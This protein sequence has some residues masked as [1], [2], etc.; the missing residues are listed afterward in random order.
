MNNKIIL[1]LIGCACIGSSA[2]AQHGFRTLDAPYV[3]HKKDSVKHIYS[4]ARV[5]LLVVKINPVHPVVGEVR[6]EVEKPVW[7]MLSLEA[8]GGYIYFIYGYDETGDYTDG[9][10]IPGSYGYSIL[11]DV[12]FYFSKYRNY[13]GLFVMPQYVFRHY[14]HTS[15]A[16]TSP[17]SLTQTINAGGYWLL[18]GY[19]LHTRSSLSFEASIGLGNTIIKDTYTYNYATHLNGTVKSPIFLPVMQVAIDYTFYKKQ[20]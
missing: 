12:R 19:K 4:D 13:T 1:L 14:T 17:G 10:T 5:P 20:K 15:Q 6:M 8:G 9:Q 18:A 2:V 7:K 11:L 3:F 16:V